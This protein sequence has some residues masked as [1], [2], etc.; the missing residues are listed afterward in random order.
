MKPARSPTRATSRAAR[1]TAEEYG[2]DGEAHGI[3]VGPDQTATHI[4]APYALSS[5]HRRGNPRLAALA[6]RAGLPF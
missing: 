4:I 3:H 6:R 5:L 2:T 1:R